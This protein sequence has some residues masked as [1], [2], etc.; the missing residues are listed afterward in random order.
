MLQ[1]RHILFKAEVANTA[2]YAVWAVT[3]GT[4]GGTHET[5]ATKQRSIFLQ[6]T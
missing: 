1:D 4:D 5:F 6:T 3:Q 2:F